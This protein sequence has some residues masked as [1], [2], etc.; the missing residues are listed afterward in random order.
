MAHWHTPDDVFVGYHE[1]INDA[2]PVDVC[3]IR[4]RVKLQLVSI[5]KKKERLME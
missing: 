2:M 4:G 3:I 1:L 5:F